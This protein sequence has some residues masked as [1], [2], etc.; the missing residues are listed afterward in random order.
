MDIDKIITESIH[1]VVSEARKKKSSK[2]KSKKKKGG[3]SERYDY[4]SYVAK[5][6]G[7]LSKG[8]QYDVGGDIDQDNT[9]IA[10]VSRKIFPD[11]TK[12]GAQSQLRK[13]LNGTR[14]MTR[15]VAR[16]LKRMKSSNEVAL[17]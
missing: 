8:D 17:D 9:N 4:S 11:H 13:I 16:I 14:P 12:T 3:G 2:Y 7:K 10:A 5:E 6:G 15:R 1:N